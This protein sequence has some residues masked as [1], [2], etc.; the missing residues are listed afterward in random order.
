MGPISLMPFGLGEVPGLELCEEPGQVARVTDERALRSR[1]DIAV[2][3]EIDLEK[4][5]LVRARGQGEGTS[6][7]LDLDLVPYGG[8]RGDEV[9]GGG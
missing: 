5:V 3:V 4:I 6:Y 1:E 8:G 2:M 9:S 7:N